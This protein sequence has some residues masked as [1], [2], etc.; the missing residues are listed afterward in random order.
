M[1]LFSG[2]EIDGFTL[3]K[4]SSIFDI[5]VSLGFFCWLTVDFLFPFFFRGYE[6]GNDYE[7]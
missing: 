1:L 2:G 6:G 7:I 4:K 5:F 3:G